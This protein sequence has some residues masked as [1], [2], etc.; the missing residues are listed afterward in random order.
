MIP[1]NF[2]QMCDIAPIIYPHIVCILARAAAIRKADFDFYV[3]YHLVLV[4]NY[5]G[6]ENVSVYIMNFTD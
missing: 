3:K 1:V 5:M 2:L 4:H 6:I